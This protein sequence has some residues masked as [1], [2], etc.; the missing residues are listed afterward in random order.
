MSGAP[1]G[2]DLLI[3]MFMI[4][5][6]LCLA[7]LGGGCTLLM[8]GSINELAGSGGG[9]LLLISLAVLGGGLGMMWIGFKLVT[10]R[11]RNGG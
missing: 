1:S 8:L 2:L 9:V 4:L 11:Y 7:L 5:A 10:G 6:G 3:G